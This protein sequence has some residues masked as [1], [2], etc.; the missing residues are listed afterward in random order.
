MMTNFKDIYACGD[1]VEAADMLTGEPTLSLLWHNARQQG[2]VAGY[3]CLGIAESYPGSQNITSLDIS[4]IHVA[5]FGCTQS[6]VNQQDNI[7]VIERLIGRKYYCLILNN[8]R[9]IGAQ[10]IGDSR[11]IGA[12]LCAFQRRDDMNEIVRTIAKSRSPWHYR[13]TE[14]IAPKLGI[15]S[16]SNK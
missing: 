4:G 5:A 3:N 10:F 9:L 7:E 11:D 13:V 12:L 6:E 1:C 15:S 2:E 14:Y 8:G 16:A